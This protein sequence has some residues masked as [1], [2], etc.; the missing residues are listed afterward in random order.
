MSGPFVA[1]ARTYA[2]LGF[3]VFPLAPGSK[4]PAIKGGRGFKDAT[5][6]HELIAC[7]ERRFPTANIAI[8][9]GDL[10]GVLVVDVDPRNGGVETLNALAAKGFLFPRCPEAMTGNGGRHLYFTNPA[11]K[12]RNTLGSGVDVKGTGGYVVAAPSWLAP[13]NAGPGG[14][15][16]WVL[17]PFSCPTP[18]LPIWAQQLLVRASLSSV[19]RS[20]DL[21]ASG[22]RS[23]NGLAKR[24][25]NSIEGERNVILNWA[26]YRAGQLAQ[27][28]ACSIDVA[29]MQLTAAALDAGLTSQEIDS[30]LTSGLRA[31]LG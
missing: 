5:G 18:R 27:T 21:S 26:A 16:Q 1:A 15:Y 22:P 10:S 30:T 6:D 17:D 28:G 31:G 23:L 14:H 2:S 9:T 3:E 13:T 29:R 19:A 25:A 7:W 4:L 24:V 11:G 8:A 12:M 20:G